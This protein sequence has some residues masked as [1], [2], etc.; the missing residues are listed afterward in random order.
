VR[1]S[2]NL[3]LLVAT[4]LLPATMSSQEPTPPTTE[5]GRSVNKQAAVT[6]DPARPYRPIPVGPSRPQETI[7]EFYFKALNPRKIHWGD[8]IDR[9]IEQ[10][11]EQSVR[12]PYFRFCAVQMGVI[13]ILL[14]LCWAWWDKLRQTN[15]ITAE[16]LADAINAKRM[17]DQRAMDAIAAYNRHMESC[18]R[19]VE[20]QTSG[21][22][23]SIGY[24][25]KFE[26]EKLQN[27]LAASRAEVERLNA[28]IQDRDAKLQRQEARIQAIETKVAQAH[29]S[30]KA[31]LIARLERAETQLNNQGP[32]RAAK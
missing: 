10:F 1:A 32:R 18:N 16:W 8:E 12:N 25:P 30:S 20:E 21:I 2:I 7:F 6:A 11:I 29:D 15:W 5:K 24:G 19:V 4:L 17:S 27:D 26:M 9:R 22:G 3:A 28:Q 14:A 13:L 31:E 23:K